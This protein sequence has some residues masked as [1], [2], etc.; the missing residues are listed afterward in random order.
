[1]KVLI[2]LIL[3]FAV[4]SVLFFHGQG[5]TLI[6]GLRYLTAKEREAYDTRKLCRFMGIITSLIAF[7]LVL[8]ALSQPYDKPWLISVGTAIVVLS[9]FAAVFVPIGWFRR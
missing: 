8:I 9:A 6:S 4:L 1:M 3:F 7:G 2:L 5:I